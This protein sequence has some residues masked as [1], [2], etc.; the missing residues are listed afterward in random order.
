MK[1]KKSFLYYVIS[2]VLWS[3]V[4]YYLVFWVCA[5]VWKPIEFILNLL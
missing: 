3:I 1:K 5:L 4:L 2:S